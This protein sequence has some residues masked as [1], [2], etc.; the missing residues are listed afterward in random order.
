VPVDSVIME[1]PAL[2]QVR[3]RPQGPPRRRQVPRVRRAHPCP[4]K[5]SFGPREGTL[6]D[7]PP[8]YI[9]A[10]RPPASGLMS[11]AASSALCSCSIVSLGCFVP[12]RGCSARSSLARAELDRAAS[13]IISGPPTGPSSR[14]STTPSWTTAALATPAFVSRPAMWPGFLLSSSVP[15]PRSQHP[16]ACAVNLGTVLLSILFRVLIALASSPARVVRGA[17]PH[18][19]LRRLRS[20][21]GCPT[22][23]AGGVSAAR[24]GSSSSS[25]RSMRSSSPASLF[26]HRQCAALRGVPFLVFVAQIAVLLARHVIG[27]ASLRLAGSSATRTRTKAAS[28][29]S[30]NASATAQNAA[31]PSQ[32]PCPASDCGYELRGLPHGGQL[33]RVRPVLRPP[34]PHAHP[35]PRKESPPRRLTHR[36]RRHRPHPDHPRPATPSSAAGPNPSTTRPS[37]SPAT[38]CPKT[39]RTLPRHTTSPTDDGPIPLADDEPRRP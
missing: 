19:H 13:W 2:P 24:P 3:L 17:D 32:A 10:R 36:H 23:P 11:A 12:Y 34:H 22:T 25:G 5:K 1:A 38:T 29:A 33:P 8:A 31:A 27:C 9:R 28:N 16:V 30:P 18:L 37:R 15:S 7:A 20:S 21:S 6:S 26:K 4:P 39:C 14:C 35:R